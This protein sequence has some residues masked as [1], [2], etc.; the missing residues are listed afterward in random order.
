MTFL[1][2]NE[3]FIKSKWN[4]LLGWNDVGALGGGGLIHYIVEIKKL[5]KYNKQNSLNT[6]Y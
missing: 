4:F 2:L 1:Q 3:T 5:T 6:H